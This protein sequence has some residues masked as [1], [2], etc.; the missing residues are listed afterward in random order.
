MGTLILLLQ[1]FLLLF[2]FVF[3]E[4]SESLQCFNDYD[5]E[6]KCSLTPAESEI[7]SEYT[8]KALIETHHRFFHFEKTRLGTCECRI[9][10]PGFVIGE[11]LK[12]Y[13]WKEGKI[14]RLLTINTGNSIKPRRPIITSVVQKANQNILVTVNTTYTK[15][16]FA[17]SLMVE[18]NYKID[19]S[20]EKETTL[21]QKGSTVH[22]I[23]VRNL[24]P[25]S[26]YVLRA[27][28]KSS[29][30]LNHTFSDY[31][32]PIKFQTQSLQ[33]FND[34]DTE[35]KCSLT[36]AV[37]E[38]CSEYTLKALIET[39]HRLVRFC[40]FEETHLGTCECRI[41]FPGFIIGE[42]LKINL[43]KGDNVWWPIMISTG[44][45][46]K[47]RRPIITSVVQKANQNIL[48]TVNT[49]YTKQPFADSLMV[50]LN[51]KIDG[52]DEKETTLLQKGST[53]HEILVRNLQPNS[54]YVLRARVKSSYPL[55]HTF[56]DY[57][58][59]IK[60]Q[61]Q[62][63]QCFNDYDTELKCSL[64]PAV[65]EICSE[66][67]LKALIETHHR[68]C[69]FEETHLGTCECRI[70]FPGFIIGEDLKI[71]LSKGD[72]VWWP[73]MISTGNS[74]KPR[75]PII[76]SVVQKANRNILI[77]VNTTYTK[78]PFSDY[79]MVELNYKI[80]GSDEKETTLLQKGST[81]HEILGR[82][83]Q[84]NSRYVLRARVKSSYP[85]NNTF[86]DYSEPIK[87]QTPI[88]LQNTLKIIIPI[89][90]IIL[91]ICI[92][93][94]YFWFYRVLK[95]WWDEIPTPKFTTN[96]VKQVPQLLSIQSEFSSV[97]PD[98]TANH[99]NKKICLESCEVQDQDR[100]YGL[101]LKKDV[102]SAPLIYSTTCYESV[103]EN[104]SEKVQLEHEKDHGALII[105]QAFENKYYWQSS[106]SGMSK[107]AVSN[108]FT[109]VLS[110]NFLVSSKNLDPK[111]YTDVN[112]CVWDG[113]TDSGTSKMVNIMPT[114]EKMDVVFGYPS[115]SWSNPI[116]DEPFSGK[117]LQDVTICSH[118]RI[119][120][121]AD[122]EYQAF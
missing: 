44:N 78:Q 17:D 80:D 52:S 47:P 106:S 75:R 84:P 9:D 3:S 1:A 4:S 39:H 118:D 45:S 71:N 72:N 74:I 68:F 110:E 26:R 99:I 50:E 13:L 46:I 96:F 48:V 38:I 28:V 6:L 51:Y 8:L 91:I 57:S 24:Q 18:L 23:L 73:I 64:T 61:T 89:L 87:F 119:V 122:E 10:V 94:I 81:V 40:H 116:I 107:P 95:P 56:S 117:K 98:S 32:E 103:N 63:L 111:I 104:S 82:N 42:D 79:L 34:Y 120:M 92:S 113:C 114:N 53:V 20:D 36:P 16:P 55:N 54:R 66:Y 25:N 88:S 115:I 85:L 14:W 76:T 33:C 90:C 21:L 31:S 121:P 69:H 49:T 7:C 43:S 59:P 27:R 22:E 102:D 67:T 29:Y 93:S 37:S 11:D 97:N 86:S 30:P 70:D 77:E 109:N 5:T 19:G 83:L 58:E 62:S 108:E 60:F 105:E 12:I 112:Y 100:H 35:L 2:G 15:Q 65:S 41:D 101:I